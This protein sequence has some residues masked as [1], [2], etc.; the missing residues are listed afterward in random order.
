VLELRLEAHAEGTLVRVLGFSSGFLPTCIPLAPLLNM[1]FFFVPFLDN[2][3]NGN[4]IKKVRAAL[5]AAGTP[6]DIYVA[7]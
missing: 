6:C 2:N 5:V 4:R 1:V 3:F 7:A